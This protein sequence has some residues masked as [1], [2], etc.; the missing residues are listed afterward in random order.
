[1]IDSPG[2]SARNVPGRNQSFRDGVLSFLVDTGERSSPVHQIFS[3]KTYFDATL[4]DLG[5]AKQ[6]INTDRV[7]IRSSLMA[8]MINKELARTNGLDISSERG[9]SALPS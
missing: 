3:V 9:L 4:V 8:M 7:L 6:V 5:F 2:V 1:M